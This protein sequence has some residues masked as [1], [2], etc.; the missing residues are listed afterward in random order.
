[1]LQILL[2]AFLIGNFLD[3]PAGSDTFKMVESESGKKFDICVD[4]GES[5]FSIRVQNKNLMY[6]ETFTVRND[7]FYISDRFM[8]MGIF[9]V[10]LS[11]FPER[12]RMI[13]PFSEDAKWTYKGVES[14]SG[15]KRNVE[16]K[17]FI[18][19]IS[20]TVVIYNI[21]KRGKGEDTTIVAFDENYNL[22][23]ITI[24]IPNILG[25]HKLLGFKSAKL[26]LIRRE[27]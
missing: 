26:N 13:T 8:R 2:F 16:S 12:I 19:I 11:Y 22:Y 6:L 17:G 10:R 15:Y 14:G 27:D 21:S 7:T 25:L 1:M 18:E 4:G 24:Q 3:F 5:S 20:D 9:S 23:R